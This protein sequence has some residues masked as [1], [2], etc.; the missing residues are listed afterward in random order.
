VAGGNTVAAYLLGGARASSGKQLRRGVE[1]LQEDTRTRRGGHEE[2]RRRARGSGHN[3]ETGSAQRRNGNALRFVPLTADDKLRDTR[4]CRAPRGLGR[5]QV[6]IRM[7]GTRGGVLA[8]GAW[9]R[10]A[11]PAVWARRT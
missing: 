10:P 9:S 1:D 8:R 4:E 5:G 6:D 11:R 2:G 3:G 7:R